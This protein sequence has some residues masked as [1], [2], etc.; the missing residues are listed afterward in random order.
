M[1]SFQIIEKLLETPFFQGISKSDLHEIVGKT[2]FGFAKYD[3]GKSI[4]RAE[5]Y[6]NEMLFVLSGTVEIITESADHSYTVSE[7][8]TAPLQ[9]QPQRLFG[10]RQRYTSTYKA[11]SPCSL[12]TLSKSEVV[13]IYNNYEV[14]RINL[15]NQIASDYQKLADR[16]WASSGN[17]LRS[18][19]VNFFKVHSYRPAGEKFFKIKMNTLAN[20]LNDSRLNVSIELNKLQNEGQISLSRGMIHVIALESLLNGNTK[21]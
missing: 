1:P 11:K 3:E 19:I 7:Y 9:I 13:K 5:S 20:E 15:L 14:F 2:K 16:Q 18:R 17:T 21:R 4:V 12:M 10:L 6:C 8:C